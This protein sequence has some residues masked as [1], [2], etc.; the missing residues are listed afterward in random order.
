LNP[1]FSMGQPVIEHGRNT[2]MVPRFGPAG[3]PALICPGDAIV[4]TEAI[5][6]KAFLI[7]IYVRVILIVGVRYGNGLIERARPWWNHG[8][9]LTGF[10]QPIEA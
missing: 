9:P 7:F 1:K 3:G 2:M 10:K 5:V 4:N 6:N 8:E